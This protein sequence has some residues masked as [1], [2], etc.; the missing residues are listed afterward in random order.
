M[1][2]KAD[3]VRLAEG[4]VNRAKAKVE[5]L[6]ASL[7]AAHDAPKHVRDSLRASIGAAQREQA[8][9][10]VELSNAK[11]LPEDPK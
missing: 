9:A 10:E 2:S 5:Q 7:G 3:K 1:A 6:T 8:S 4:K 11:L